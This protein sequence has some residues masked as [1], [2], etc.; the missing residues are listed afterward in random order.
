MRP[1]YLPQ[2]ERERR[3]RMRRGNFALL[4]FLTVAA[5]LAVIGLGTVVQTFGRWV[6]AWVAA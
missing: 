5:W 4:V 3:Q 1:L 2:T 6:S